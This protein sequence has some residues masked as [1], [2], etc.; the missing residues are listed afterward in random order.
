VENEGGNTVERETILYISDQATNSNPV[1]AALKATDYEVV[2]T[3]SPT[4]GIALLFIMHSVAAVVLNQRAREQTGFD[5]VRSLRAI[6]PDVP[7]VLLGCDQIDLLPSRVDACVST[8]QP[9]EKLA[10]AVRRL[11]AARP[12]LVHSAQS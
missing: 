9:L 11:L 3:N 8:G 1:L 5:V 10:S 4:Q 7:I 2:R 6:R 12:F